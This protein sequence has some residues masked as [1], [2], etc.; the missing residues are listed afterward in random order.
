MTTVNHDLSGGVFRTD[1]V[2]QV[3][4]APGAEASGIVKTNNN[5]TVRIAPGGE[6]HVVPKAQSFLQ[7]DIIQVDLDNDD[8][9]TS[10]Y[11]FG[12]DGSLTLTNEGSSFLQTGSQDDPNAGFVFTA[13]GELVAT[14]EE[15]SS[16]LESRASW[17]TVDGRYQRVHDDGDKPQED[18]LASNDENEIPRW[19][20]E[21]K[22]NP[23]RPRSWSPEKG[24]WSSSAGEFQGAS[25]EEN[26][27]RNGDVTPRMQVPRADSSSPSDWESA[28]RDGYLGPGFENSF[29]MESTERSALA[30]VPPGSEARTAAILVDGYDRAIKV[31][32]DD[33]GKVDQATLRSSMDRVT[34]TSA[35]MKAPGVNCIIVPNAEVDLQPGPVRQPGE[36]KEKAVLGMIH[37]D[38]VVIPSKDLDGHLRLLKHQTQYRS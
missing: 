10:A 13:N 29:R 28:A 8:D 24:S 23:Q 12:P 20:R 21:L 9:S 38:G 25:E 34:R 14:R 37:E 15:P 17:R 26:K 22:D 7:T 32:L 2:E 36:S 35:D 6:V 5:D 33:T 27:S 11:V 31:N 4:E 18:V 19:R 1:A 3:F 30:V 16:F